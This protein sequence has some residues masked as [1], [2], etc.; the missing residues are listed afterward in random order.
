M[1]GTIILSKCMHTEWIL[2]NHAKFRLLQ[3][4]PVY[5]IAY[6]GAAFPITEL[7]RA[8]GMSHYLACFC[9]I[10]ASDATKGLSGVV[11]IVGDGHQPA[12]VKQQGDVFDW[13]VKVRALINAMP[14]AHSLRTVSFIR[15]STRQIYR[16]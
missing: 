7:F 10:I 5:L 8:R 14:L 16:N 15:V 9:L 11:Q 6:G 2:I 13:F 12:V 4:K 3:G 1:S